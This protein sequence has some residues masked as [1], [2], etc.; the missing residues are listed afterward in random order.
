M[1]CL[2]AS[3][4]ER[5]H[6]L[7]LQWPDPRRLPSPCHGLGGPDVDLPRLSKPRSDG[8]ACPTGS[9]SAQPVPPARERT[10]HRGSGRDDDGVA[11]P[12]QLTNQLDGRRNGI[13]LSSFVG[14]D[15]SAVQVEAKAHLSSDLAER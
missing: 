7:A 11:R 15:Q 2:A 6:G 3:A 4:T 8:E 12:A 5:Y 14:V 10:T 1:G 9:T 13:H